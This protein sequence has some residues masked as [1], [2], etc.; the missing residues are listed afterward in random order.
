MDKNTLTGLLMMAAIVFGFMWLNQPSKEELERQR[1][2]AEKIAAEATKQ[3]PDP[4]VL[5]IDTVSPAEI[6]NIRATVR[7]YGRLDTAANLYTLASQG[8][9]IT[10]SDETDRLGGFV[11]TPAGEVAMA[12]ILTASYPA[13]V[14]PATAAQ[15]V[16]T[17]RSALADVARYKGFARYLSGDSSTVK[18]SNGDLTLEIAN[19]GG[20]IAR[21]T[22]NKYQRY[23]SAQVELISP[24][25]DRM[26]F[27]L[28][29]ATNRFDT[30][31][32]FFTPTE[33]TDSSVTMALDLGDG[34]HFAFRYTLAGEGYLVKM[35]ML[36]QGM[37]AVI[38]SSVTSVDFSW[39]QKM[40]RNEA[41]RMFEERNSGLYYMYEGDDVD[42][43][44]ENSDDQEELS[45][46]VKWI[47][48]KNQFFSSVIVA[49]TN[50]ASADISSKV[51]KDSPSMLK[52]LSTEATLDYSPTL[53]QPV[54]FTLYLGPNSY[55]ILSDLSETIAPDSDLHLTKLIPLGWALFRWINTWIVIPVFNILGQWISN[56]GIIILLLTIFIKIILFPFT[57]KSYIS[58]A[59]MRVLAPEIKEINDKWPGNEN[60]M[61][62][63]QET[64]ALYSRAGASPFSGCLPLLLQMP[65]LIAMF[66]FFPSAIEL[67]GQSFLW[68]KDLSAPDAIVSWT[69][70]IPF[71]SSTFGNHIS[72][73]CLLMTIVNIIYTKINMASQPGGASMPGMKWMTYLMPLMF[74]VF[75]NNYAAG[76]SYYYLLSLLITIIQTYIFRQVINEDKVRTQMAENARKPKKKSGFMARLEEAQRQQQAMLRE[77]QKRAGKGQ[78]R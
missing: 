74:L 72:L 41:G 29:S 62:R 47:A 65:I 60:A 52:E 67:R 10:L 21:A 45:N 56:Y 25:T 7:Q 69:T 58:Q 54:A 8:A 76:L 39:G 68:A 46:R 71:I 61:K 28:T 26:G 38:P 17:L 70:N 37:Q 77:Q 30:G 15:A 33:V 78:R 24:A 40:L 9:N 27:T 75:F 59:K 31:D 53:E 1:A 64:M 50:F 4:D 51:L 11:S 14:T 18:L 36:Q 57:Y 63:Q 66:N 12:D 34:A 2:E 48:Y 44:S 43:L 19:K 22:L 32:F 3:A 23:D 5:T 73:F 20:M 42:N 13:G 16:K 35:E 55:P 49:A 6:D